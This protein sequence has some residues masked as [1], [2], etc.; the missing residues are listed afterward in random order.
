M[1]LTPRL[2]PATPIKRYKRSLGD[3]ALSSGEQITAPT[4]TAHG[5]RVG[6]HTGIV[7]GLVRDATL[8]TGGINYHVTM[9]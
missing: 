4:P 2:I 7:N 9:L 5:T 3:V 8:P 1:L 6:V